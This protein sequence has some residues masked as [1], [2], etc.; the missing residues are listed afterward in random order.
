MEN[1]EEN[2]ESEKEFWTKEEVLE[3][4]KAAN[5]KYLRLLAEFDNWKRR[6]NKEKEDLK[7]S[8]KSNVLAAILDFDSDLTLAKKSGKIDEEG[9]DLIFSK[10]EKFLTNQGI[11]TI[12]TDTYDADLHEVI[13][14]LDIN[15]DKI[16]DVVSKG[17]MIGGKPFRYPKIVLGRKKSEN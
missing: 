9:I 14:V 4:E 13:S 2:L 12:Q 6:V 1:M 17:Y 11:E 15:E 3:I 5:D 7:L 10:V 16:I 8:V